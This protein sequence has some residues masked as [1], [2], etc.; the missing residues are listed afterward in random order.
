[1][2]AWR[3]SCAVTNA[4][5]SVPAPFAVGFLSRPD[6]L[7]ASYASLVEAR[8]RAPA[9]F[10][11]D[12]R[13]RIVDASFYAGYGG[14]IVFAALSGDGIGVRAWGCVHL[15]LHDAAISFRATVVPQNSYLL[16]ERARGNLDLSNVAVWED[17]SLIC[18]LKYFESTN[19][20]QQ[21]TLIDSDDDRSTADFIEVHIYRGFGR[22]AI[23]ACEFTDPPTHED[24]VLLQYVQEQLAAGVR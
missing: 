17:R 14:D 3:S 11:D 15:Q 4:V 16:H 5:V 7:Y 13:R 24:R 6:S 10:L 8:V 23:S 18:V 1:M 12:R 22:A 9:D 20:S 2:E 21:Q 19:P